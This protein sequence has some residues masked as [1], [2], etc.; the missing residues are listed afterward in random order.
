MKN[1]KAFTLVELL[2]VV[3][4][5]GVL[6]VILLP[7]INKSDKITKEKMLLTKVETTGQALVVWAGSNRECFTRN[8]QDNEECMLGLNKGCTKKENI[9]KCEVTYEDL[10]SFGIINYDTEENDII[11][12]VSKTSMKNEKVELCYNTSTKTFGIADACSKVITTKPTTRSNI[13]EILADNEGEESEEGLWSKSKIIEITISGGSYNL[14][15]T[16]KVK[17]GFSESKSVK[18]TNEEE[19]T[20]NE[21][22]EIKEKKF[23]VAIDNVTGIYYLHIDPEVKTTNEIEISPKIMGPY[24]LDNTAPSAPTMSFVYG[25][26]SSYNGEW[27][28][29]NIYVA[30]AAGIADGTCTTQKG[31]PSGS[32][33]EHSGIGKYQ[34][35]LDNQ[36]WVNYSYNCN[37]ELY[38]I[39]P[40]EGTSGETTRYFRACDRAE[41]CSES[42]SV[43]A[44]IDKVT[45]TVSIKA[46][47]TGTNTEVGSNTWS[48]TGLDFKLTKGSENNVSNYTIKYC[49]DTNNTC[50]PNISATNNQVISDFNAVAG[51]YYIRYQITSGANVSSEI[52]SYHAKIDV[53]NPTVKVT[54]YKYNGSA[55]NNVGDLVKNTSTYTSDG[56]FTISDSWVSYGATFK[57]ETSALSGVKSIVWKWNASESTTDTMQH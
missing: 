15:K 36:T 14:E 23:E 17:Y 13:P 53:A 29:Q 26:F 9:I 28:N 37:N 45:P 2:A 3:I 24:Y 47:K 16:G 22:S 30:Q 5:L 6:S 54:G 4:I 38:K 7:T 43:V 1:N 46:F 31:S 40:A 32:V 25:D 42:I 41:N 12:P 20:Y 49:K 52:G 11:N 48:A 19:Y 55:S 34:I 57:F 27:T 18:P 10:A 39:A 33:D 35:S 56:T 8:A 50:T 44:K 51:E 21:A